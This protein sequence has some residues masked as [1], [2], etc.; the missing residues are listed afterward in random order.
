MT[1]KETHFGDAPSTLEESLCMQH[2]APVAARF[3]MY[4]VCPFI[5]ETAGPPRKA[6]HNVAV[7]IGRDGKVVKS[8]AGHDAY[9][10][11]FPVLYGG[12]DEF[13][14]KG[15]T[16]SQIGV[17]AWDLDFGRISVLICFDVSIASPAGRS[18]ESDTSR[19]CVG[20]LPRA[21]ARCIGPRS[22]DRDLA[23][24]HERRL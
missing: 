15:I 3:R 21:V 20:E 8:I 19:V 2:V 9:R 24:H 18:P 10:K 7:V 6:R 13:G 14:E 22:R 17:Q 5:E 4:I 11:S 16:P 1:L 12:V 23:E